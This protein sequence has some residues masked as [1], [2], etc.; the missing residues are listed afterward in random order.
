MTFVTTNISA[1]GAISNMGTNINTDGSLNK[2]QMCELK[3]IYQ[4][5]L[6][7]N[8]TIALS[9]RLDTISPMNKGL[10]LKHYVYI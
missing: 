9:T 3:N 6:A 10:K 4:K 2:S 8:N 1:R 7:T 5:P